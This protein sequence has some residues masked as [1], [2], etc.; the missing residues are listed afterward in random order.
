MEA[1]GYAKYFTE[2][3]GLVFDGNHVTP[4][5]GAAKLAR[6]E[7]LKVFPFAADLVSAEHFGEFLT[8]KYY[9]TAK[10][11]EKSRDHYLRVGAEYN[12]RINKWTGLDGLLVNRVGQP[13]LAD[14]RS[15]TLFEGIWRL[16]ASEHLWVEDQDGDRRGDS[17]TFVHADS[18]RV[19]TL[20]HK[21]IPI[22]ATR[23]FEVLS[24]SYDYKEDIADAVFYR[25]FSL[26]APIRT[27][28]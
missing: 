10:E 16:I 20:M 22:F 2:E 15:A 1:E 28:I 12:R 14:E 6:F 8:R 21:I 17:R 7:F 9:N 19:G 26:S 24:H 13:D 3:P 5:S 18:V 27:R 4:V 25:G 11:Q 23:G